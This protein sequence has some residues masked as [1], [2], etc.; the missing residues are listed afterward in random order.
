MASTFDDMILGDEERFDIAVLMEMIEH[1]P[2]DQ[3]DGDLKR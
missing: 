3:V 2:A 1:L